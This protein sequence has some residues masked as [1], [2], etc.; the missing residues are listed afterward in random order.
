MD[1]PRAKNRMAC[2]PSIG[3]KRRKD[4]SKRM[5]RLILFSLIIYFVYVIYRRSQEPQV[6][7]LGKDKVSSKSSCPPPK[8]FIDYTEG[9]I[10]GKK[11]KD[12]D[13]HMAH[14]KDCQDALNGVFGMSKK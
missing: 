2:G 3:I 9:R 7:G 4:G 10:K 1:R 14:C 8:T 6:N 11:K 13:S 5:T 12:I